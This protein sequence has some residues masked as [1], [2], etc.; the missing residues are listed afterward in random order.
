MDIIKLHVVKFTVDAPRLGS[1]CHNVNV[2][3]VAESA[4]KSKKSTADVVINPV[5][6]LKDAAPPELILTGVELVKTDG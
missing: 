4:D 6:G 5:V 3:D 1:Y 2:T